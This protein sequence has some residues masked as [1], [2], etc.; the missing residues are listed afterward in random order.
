MTRTLSETWSRPWTEGECRNAR[1]ELTLLMGR[2]L[3]M[4]RDGGQSWSPITLGML[5]SAVARAEGKGAE[6]EELEYL[7]RG[8]MQG[9]IRDQEAPI[10]KHEAPPSRCWMTQ[11]TCDAAWCPEHGSSIG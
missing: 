4:T 10:Q 1:R 5:A 7:M 2:P 3:E 9:W 11:Q 6:P 8:L